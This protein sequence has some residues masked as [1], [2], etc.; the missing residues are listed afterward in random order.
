M[1]QISTLRPYPHDA[2]ILEVKGLHCTFITLFFSLL[3]VTKDR[4]KLRISH[5]ETFSSAD[6]LANKN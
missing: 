3:K 1:S 4:V 2:N 6:P 5:T